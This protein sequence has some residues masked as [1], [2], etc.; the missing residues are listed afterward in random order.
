MND[1]LYAATKNGGARCN[2]RNLSISNE[3]LSPNGLVFTGR[4]HKREDKNI[5]ADILKDLEPK[6][7]HIRRWGSAA[8]M[9]AVVAAGQA[10]AVILTGGKLWDAAAGVLLVKESGGSV[11]D[12]TGNA[13]VPSSRAL[14]AGNK[15]T[16]KEISEITAKYASNRKD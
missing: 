13:W 10:E 5:H 8:L 14:V 4:W 1:L 7:P 2:E 11:T 9:L 16:H 3:D 6:I 12:Q 15:N